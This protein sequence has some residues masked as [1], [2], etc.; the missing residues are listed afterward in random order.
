MAELAKAIEGLSA[1]ELSALLS[2]L[3]VKK[4]QADGDRIARQ[5]RDGGA[6]PLSF[7]QQRIWFLDQL[8]PGNPAYNV[9]GAIAI[10]GPL[11][12]G[13]LAL[14]LRAVVRRH[15]ALRTR[16]PT[17]GGQPVQVVEEGDELALPLVDLSGLPPAQRR[18]A[19]QHLEREE[20]RRPFQLE[21]GGLLRVALLRLGEREHTLLLVLHHIVADA[22]SAGL[23]MQELGTLYGAFARGEPSPLPELP[24]QYVDF[25]V[26]QR[27]HLAQVQERQ[28][29]FWR[30]QLAGLP[31][32]ELPADRL[33]PAV[34]SLRGARQ[35]L[36][37]PAPVAAALGRLD[38]QGV[39]PFVALSAAFATLL[40]RYGGQEDVAVGAPV[41]SRRLAALEGSIGFFANTL[42]L[43]TDLAGDPSFRELL[44]RV[45]SSVADALSHQDLPF[46]RLVEVLAPQRD[47]GH[48]PLVRA[49]FAFQSAPLA[50]E[51]SGLAL[52][53]ADVDNGTAK[54][55]LLL[56]LVRSPDG[57]AGYVEYST[58][59]FDAPTVARIAG[60]FRRLV[61][62][63]VTSPGLRLSEL[64][65]LGEE[66]R[67]QLVAEWN[68]TAAGP[69]VG[70]GTLHE[71]FARQVARTPDAPAV[72]GR[73]ESLTYREL[74][75]R[76][77]RLASF[78]R[79]LGVGPETAVAICLERSC[80][81]VVAILGVLATG[82]A[83]VPLDPAYPADRLAF[84]LADS[85][86]AAVVTRERLLPAI[87][88]GAARAVLLDAH[89]EALAAASPDLPAGLGGPDHL[90][91][92]IYTSGSTGR[93]KGVAIRQG[94]AVARMGWAARA[95]SAAEIA[96]VLAATSICFDLSIFEL[97]VPLTRGG[98]V[99]LA[100]NVLELPE[101]PLRG[102]VTL[103]N[104]VPSAMAELVR[105]RALPASLRVVN[106]AGEAF[107]PALARA[108]AERAPECRILNLYGPSEDTTYSTWAAVSGADPRPP[109]IGRPLAGT[110]AHVLGRRLEL[111]PI[112]V[113]G[114]LCIGGEG[115][116]RG[117]FRRPEL[118]AERFIPDPFAAL[119]GARLYRT[120][121]LARRRPDGDLEF[122]GRRDHQVKVRGFR[123]ELGEVEA[124]LA[125]Q[126]QVREAVVVAQG[127]AGQARL[128]AYVVPAGAAIDQAELRV[129]LARRLPTAMVPGLFVALP[130]LP[131]TPNGKLD[132]RALP[133]PE[134]DSTPASAAGPR[135][136][137]EEMVA[138]ICAELLGRERVGIFDSFFDLG[139][140]S[141]LATRLASRLG[142]AFQ[143]QL[144]VRAVFETP[145]VAA[146][147]ARLGGELRRRPVPPVQRLPRPVDP[148]L[149][150]GQE[151]LWFL[152]Q[153]APESAL[154]NLP[155]ALRLRGPLEVAALL[156][157]LA[158]VALRHE[159]L[160]TRFAVI[161]ER[162]V[163]RIAPEP[164]PP[165]LVCDLAALPAPARE[166]EAQR[167]TAAE[168]RRPFDLARGPLA[169]WQLL[170]LAPEDHVLVLN[171]HHAV[172]DGWSLGI[173]VRELGALYRSS[174][175]PPLPVQ[176]VDYARWQRE[177]LQG[178]VLDEQLAYWRRRLAAP[179]V[180]D[181]PADRPRPA[182]RAGRG[183][184]LAVE[185]PGELV[186]ALR[187][188]GR[189]EGVTL[190]MVLLAGFQA[191]LARHADRSDVA[192]GAPVAHRARPELEGLIGFFVNTLVLRVDLAGDPPLRGLL[193][194]VREAALGAY[195][196]QDLPFE[197]LVE[198]LQPERDASRT[199]LVQSV[200]VL[201]NA[202]L[203]TLELPGV[204]CEAAEVSTG[205]AKFDLTLGLRESGEA[206]TG[207]LEYDRD[208]FDAATMRR[209]SGHLQ[210]LL[211]N[212]ASAPGARLSDL[213]LLSAGE[214]H[215][216]GAEWNDA[217]R[218]FAAGDGCL[219]TLI[220]ARVRRTPE[221]VALVCAG[222]TLTYAELNA[223][224]NRLARHLR[225]LGVGR[226]D[227]V[228]VCLERSAGMVAGLLAVLKAGAAYVPLDPGY[229]RE[230]LAFMLAD[231]QVRVLLTQ[232]AFSA[233]LPAADGGAPGP[234]TLCLDTD[235]EPVDRESAADLE[236]FPAD[237][238]L[239]Y[240]IYTSG[241]TG[242]PKG[243]ENTHR[244]IVNR[245]LWMQET[246]PLQ[247]CDR[248]LQK[249][250]FSFDVSVP[251]LFWPLLAGARLV[252]ARPG[253]HQDPAYL[254]QLIAEQG[255]T[256]A[257]FVPS[258]LQA[259]VEEPEV[260]LCRSLR[261]VMASG[262]ALPCELQAR[263]FARF[264]GVTEVA[265]YNLY[266][267]TEAAVEVTFHRCAP[268]GARE[269]VPIGRPVANTRIHLLDRH[270][271][272]VPLGVTG[273]L[274][275]GGVQVARGYFGRP[276]LTAE[277]FV[278]DALGGEPG[279]R[280][281]RTGDL[282]RHVPNGEVEYLGRT[283]QQV[284]LR[285]FRIELGEI[286]AALASHP[287]VREAVVLA[288]TDGAGETRL[289]AYVV[290]R[291]DGRREL[292]PRRWLAQRLPD[293][294]VP[295]VFVELAALPLTPSGKVDRQRL[296][297]P[298]DAAPAA[299]TAP[300]T[301]IEELVC[302]I[303]AELLGVDELGP[304]ASFFGAGGH[305]LLAARLAAR[306]RGACGIELPLRDLFEASTLADLAGRVEA[307][308]RSGAG[309]SSGSA[310]SAG[311]PIPRAAGAGP[312]PLSF[313][314]ERIWFLEQLDPGQGVY[315]MPAAARLRGVL[316]RA[317]L[318]RA[319]GEV[320]H[321][322]DALR[323]RFPGRAG[324][325]EQVVAPAAAVALPWID[326]SAL[327]SGRRTPEAARLAQR[328]A[329]AGFDLAAGPLLRTRLLDLG[330]LGHSLLFNVHHIVADA[331][332]V[333]VLLR[334]VVALYE[335]FTAGLPSPLPELPI[336]Y[337]DY[338]VWQ[339]GRRTAAAEAEL[340]AYWRERL[341][342]APEGL[343]LPADR[344]RAA[345]STYRGGRRSLALGTRLSGEVGRLAR[346]LRA[347]PF[348]VLL[349]AVNVLLQRHTG[350]DDVIVGFP[351]AVRSRT[352][353]EG[354]V[355]IFLNTLPLRVDLAGDPE[356]AGLVE[357]VRDACLA[358]YARQDLPF[359]RILAAL[360]PDRERGRGPLFQVLFNMLD[361]PRHERT[362]GGLEIELSPPAEI[363]SKFDL[364]FY[365]TAQGEE[366]IGFDLVYNA[367]LFL[368]ER[369]EELLRQLREVLEQATEAPGRRL[370]ELSLVTAAAAARLPS[371]TLELAATWPGTVH[372]RLAEQARR[373]PDAAAVVAGGETWSYRDLDAESSRLA[374]LLVAGGVQ[375]E[376]A[377]AV[378]GQR[379]APL[380]AALLGILKARAAF[381][382]LD[383]AYP[384]L[385]LIDRLRIARPRSWIRV[386]GTPVPE[387]LA[388]H[389]DAADLRCRIELGPAPAGGARERRP[390]PAKDLQDLE[391]CGGPG[392]LAYLAFTSGSTGEPKALLG[393]HGPL[394]HFLHWHA[395]TFAFTR[396]DRFAML[397]GLAHDPLLRDVFTPLWVGATLCVPEPE[398]LASPSR[399][400]AWLRQQ[401]ITVVHLT[402]A[403]SE[404]LAAGG[405]G[406]SLP[407]LRYA[408]FGGAPLS[409]LDTARLRRLA[410]AVTCVNFYGTTETPQA[411]SVH[412]VAPQEIGGE[413]LI[414]LG[415]GIEGVQLLVLRRS[416][417][418][419]GIGELGEEVEATRLP[420]VRS[421]EVA[422]SERCVR[423]GVPSR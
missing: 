280:L 365:V 3:R 412:V 119:A 299:P 204:R 64:P 132:R 104:T 230:R 76:A 111:A 215:Q 219:H 161:D 288:R 10:A 225:R 320:V 31:A 196:H 189:A 251:E 86:A 70:A 238:A 127:E 154:Y 183:G 7:A 333:A 397:S 38:V 307:A 199:P 367:D 221:A 48:G 331:W 314:Q 236:P 5:P 43:R 304:A 75:S 198:E 172:C 305:S 27:Q 108:L 252:V 419:C 319:L 1:R 193:A 272:P 16:F 309:L 359:E 56:N 391:G 61:E 349:A 84:M 156:A 253:G 327:P 82:G 353:L 256:I 248:V 233:S 338:A 155:F 162:P 246:F 14:A 249:T 285:G 68:D 115:L 325:P 317:A 363:P 231:A 133:A 335:A 149:S 265:L 369:S 178:E 216:I 264:A 291:A 337:V 340:L 366:G 159:S 268:G 399:M 348:M 112:G 408:F 59:L 218:R 95:F 122:L 211:A 100:E 69:A 411:M 184:T 35:P 229:P 102:Q 67:Q 241:S 295:A 378:Y 151:R 136:P 381:L 46:E 17:Q 220:E 51:L 290:P 329:V 206:L 281:Y 103:V 137:I 372:A 361:L 91:Y 92:V 328:E 30:R 376:E 405:T 324:R 352:E 374:R 200:L 32:L 393:D 332:S 321:R 179:P 413:Q 110:R 118:T 88:P 78:L 152:H 358:A 128:V 350:S 150:F 308:L 362:A 98:T 173:L 282:A 245:L 164:A 301:P 345:L 170:R 188:L 26:W 355:G 40:L 383:P 347:T 45:R 279:A 117:Y 99:I 385:R 414:P 406:G 395:G 254:A 93:P 12:A 259:F 187:E 346:R 368:A 195:G 4:G 326:L 107:P 390:E 60:H 294:M 296:P 401:A 24:V 228:G 131:R 145:T 169:R 423:A 226:G 263:F 139:G 244:G 19:V 343:T 386:A 261:L 80:E 146:L 250:P 94:S 109:A 266:G 243:V 410:P 11:L 141:L 18:T 74:A 53:L 303:A 181:L 284:K 147:A 323:A 315:N 49:L 175:L 120:G 297:A 42:V 373:Q 418:L 223:R 298:P 392:A 130:E 262:E 240:M 377:V 116:A 396:Q 278:P 2:R 182:R 287:G 289:V 197:K 276:D 416:E 143:T 354:I 125:A 382:V 72:A 90:A 22:W 380:V 271:R 47:L 126:P 190:F 402:P 79:T 364:T 286:E 96:G 28:L 344:P 422:L 166:R 255:V 129:A 209:L 191:L 157:G 34:Q 124:A 356:L 351:I 247:G 113:P 148:P 242:R 165:P 101:L 8:D 389:L 177:W 311:G 341:A 140:H 234:L 214:A 208:L 168:A 360:Q 224:A 269:A 258:M 121:D 212:A 87:G 138:A 400:L 73:E 370:S 302:G 312:Y 36:S 176:Y 267:P 85:A 163:Q 283:D 57:F 20:A 270:G 194:D 394:S 65:L 310:G 23:L 192:V 123:I 21:Q 306:I 339:R 292:E 55:D 54:L 277:R 29:E 180:L 58:D 202:P 201:Q 403:L 15:E 275:I 50:L 144:P 322:H 153:M 407:D 300:R 398:D 336:R 62:A 316:D 210:N 318:G 66:E 135:H 97:F 44:G 203:G 171:L 387:E 260:R 237:E 409:G 41:S 357:R 114:E 371:P 232:S 404:V 71:M 134:A 167:L 37:L 222:E 106:L 375:P 6:F 174:P 239:A 142:D 415:R 217:G 379:S 9:A 293:S 33:R 52:Q 81:M 83:Y 39:T 77:R 227:R 274:H 63:A 89:R 207:V 388:R 342:G 235:G 313:S 417:S 420:H 213:S 273:E 186:R 185:L 25:A 334:E 330:E 384:A 105:S 421:L 205:T 257:H 13:V 160:R 158:A